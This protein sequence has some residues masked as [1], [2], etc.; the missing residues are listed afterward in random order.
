MSVIA[1]LEESSIPPVTV[2]V[3]AL[4]NWKIGLTGLFVWLNKYSCLTWQIK[5]PRFI[6]IAF[7]TMLAAV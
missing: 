5:T 3:T 4:L 1:G 2:G 6:F 7:E